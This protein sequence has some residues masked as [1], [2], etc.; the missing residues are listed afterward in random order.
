MTRYRVTYDQR[1][2]DTE[3]NMTNDT[4]WCAIRKSHDSS[5]EYISETGDLYNTVKARIN[6]NETLIPGWHRANPIQRIER[7]KLVKHSVES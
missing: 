7:Y 3:D 4:L 1:S 2:T 5:T 6:V